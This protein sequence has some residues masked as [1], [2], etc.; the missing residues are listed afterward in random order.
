MEKYFKVFSNFFSNS[1]KEDEN[2]LDQDIFLSNIL[3]S[4]KMQRNRKINHY[5]NIQ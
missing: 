5:G 1:K 3:Y 2:K 4:Y